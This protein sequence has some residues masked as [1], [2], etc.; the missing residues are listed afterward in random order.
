MRVALVIFA[1]CYTIRVIRNLLVVIYW[2]PCFTV[3]RDLTTNFLNTIFILSSDWF[4]ILAML[5]VHHINYK[6]R[7]LVETSKASESS[8]EKD[9]FTCKGGS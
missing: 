4:A 3:H 6:E 1:V 9:N 5:I 7:P 8:T 2:T